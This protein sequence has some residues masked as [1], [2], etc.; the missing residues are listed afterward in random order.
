MDNADARMRALRLVMADV[1]RRHDKEQWYEDSD[2]VDRV[3]GIESDEDLISHYSRYLGGCS[4]C[5]RDMY[6]FSNR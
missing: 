2:V 1:A 5:D 6:D 4:R 3:L